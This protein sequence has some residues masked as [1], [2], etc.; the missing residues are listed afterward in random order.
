MTFASLFR[1]QIR[2]LISRA[3]QTRR[4]DRFR[5]R[6]A[7]MGLEDRSLPSIFFN[8][9]FG[10]EAQ[11][12]DGG[13]SLQS[14]PVYL[15]FWG[16][17]WGGTNSAAANAIKT[18]AAKVL[19]SPY[20]SGLRQYHSDGLAQLNSLAVYDSSNPPDL[21]FAEGRI[22][23]VVQNQIDNGPLPESD[24]TPH[25]P[26][27]VV[28]TPPGIQSSY[29][30]NVAG[31]NYLGHDIDICGLFCIDYDDI[32][33]VWAWTGN[34]GNG[35]INIDQFTL[36]LSHEVA[37]IMSD[38]GGGGY[39]VYPG[40]NWRGGG[41]GNQIGD[42][43]GNAY[44]WRE[45]NGA[46]VQ[47]Y[48]SARDQRWLAPDG[49][50]QAMYLGPIWNGTSY[51]GKNT[52]AVNGDQ[53]P[54]HDDT[55]S[56]SASGGGVLVTLNGEFFQFD[57]GQISSIIINT[58]SG[59]DTVSIRSTL[60]G[61]PVTVNLGNGNDTVTVGDSDLGAI[62]GSVTIH[63]GLGVDT[64]NVNDWFSSGAHTYTLNANTVQRSGSAFIDYGTG[65]NFV[66]INGSLGSNNIYNVNGTEAGWTTILSTGNGA[67]TVNVER[68]NSGIFAV[69]EGSGGVTV[70]LS[71]VAR[72]LNNI[73]GTVNISGST[74]GTDNLII[75]DQNST[76]VQT[77]TLSA[78]SLIRSG[79]GR[80][81][82]NDRMSNVTLSGGSGANT[83]N[84]NS[85]GAITVT[86][87]NTGTGN[88]NVNVESAARPL[89]VN[90]QGTGTNVIHMSPV[91]QNLDNIVAVV[92]VNG[93]GGNTTLSVDDQ[94]KTTQRLFG[95]GAN[96]V[97]Y[98]GGVAIAFSN[99]ANVVVNG[100]SGNNTYTVTGTA[101]SNRT[102]VN[103]G[104]GTDTVN[105]EAVNQF[106]SVNI[107][108]AGSANI[109]VNVCPTA[110]NLNNIQG[111]LNVTGNGGQDDTLTLSDF[112]N[113]TAQTYTLNA[114]SM[115]RTGMAGRVNYGSFSG[116]VY[117]NAYGI[118]GGSTVN[119]GGTIAH[120]MTSVGVAAGNDTVNV[121]AVGPLSSVSV[122][123]GGPGNVVNISPVAQNLNNL[124]GS[125][126]VYGN[127][128]STVLVVNDQNNATAQVYAV[129]SNS[130]SRTGMGGRVSFQT[131]SSTSSVTLNGGAAANTYNIAGAGGLYTT[132]VNTSGSG[133]TVNVLGAPAAALT[134]NTAPY[135]TVAVGSAAHV[136]DPI[137]AVSVNDPT[138]TA[139]VVVDDSG[140]G[141]AEDYV[142]T[143]ATVTIGRSTGFT[144]AYSGIALLALNGG[145]AGNVYELDSTSVATTVNGGAGA[146]CF[147]VSPFTQ[148]L[149]ASIL[150]PLT[151]NGSGSDVLDFFDANDPNSETYTFDATP[152]SLTL[153]STGTTF[154]TFGGMGSIYVV[155]NGIST[156]DDASGQVIFDPDG[157]PACGPAGNPGAPAHGPARPAT[158]LE[159]M[160]LSAAMPAAEAGVRD[161]VEV[162]GW[163]RL[164]DAVFGRRLPP[165]PTELSWPELLGG[166]N[167][168]DLALPT[169][170]ARP[171]SVSATA[172]F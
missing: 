50:S 53:R 120:S 101:T 42:Y 119:V 61:V 26:I 49:N 44:A 112:N 35:T 11:K 10:N 32:P 28:V 109:S 86:T 116:F 63:A 80:I 55:I 106:A 85:T 12:Q 104:T 52:L 143:A 131:L 38:L 139:I 130:V 108:E 132:T 138:G 124:Q 41:S 81:N 150:G 73:Q 122:Y 34:N 97:A 111:T 142:V 163:P 159:G 7:L 3:R 170:S 59:N 14:P 147:H 91:G 48:W 155:T 123:E 54:S 30:R 47:P 146:N 64:L 2:R 137:G 18:A 162:Q 117:V 96:V 9:V 21:G 69:N 157:G 15:I 74:A 107:N 83:Y 62:Q 149:A 71:P 20:L 76:A 29:G 46:L 60:P 84:V 75:N 136:L 87:V 36:T 72:T 145:S 82:T 95:I 102:T 8:P 165:G 161:S 90:V 133:N 172:L 40:P 128:G 68:T 105:V 43:E 98:S 23:D 169:K 67:D 153:G 152:S 140:F 45:P 33:E 39:E 66:N 31:F 156:P 103:T 99:M 110:K 88:D 166:F 126:T 92:H 118:S 144:V 168:P 1:S 27:Y 6:P 129:T 77:Y 4:L 154:A 141:T 121:E 5:C 100:G 135:D 167:L 151:L 17:W 171:V 57:P 164:V 78:G 37:E 70:N 148:Y 58:G 22:D 56:I 24:A 125:V 13:A 19:S 16:S 51:T 127:S 160:M 134:V 158:A 115:S 25:T 79:S 94:K 114:G 65:I 113:T 93:S 89:T